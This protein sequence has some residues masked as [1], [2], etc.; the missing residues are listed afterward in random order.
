[1]KKLSK[2]IV[3]IFFVTTSVH[4][5]SS[6]LEMSEP[7]LLKEIKQLLDKPS[8]AIDAD[9]E[10]DVTFVFNSKD[11]IV[12]LSVD[13]KSQYAEG[14]IKSRLNYQKLNSKFNSVATRYKLPVRITK[15]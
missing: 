15:Q 10:A 12:V 14:F 2:V 9:I 1:M 8:F 3:V 11:E 4:A 5:G 6:T 13:S 7:E